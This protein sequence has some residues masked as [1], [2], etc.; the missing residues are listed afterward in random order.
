MKYILVFIFTILSFSVFPQKTIDTCFT[1][2]QIINIAHNIKQL[3]YSDSIKTNIIYHQDTII[4]EQ[5][6]IITNDSII[7]VNDSIVIAKFK[8]NEK[9]FNGIVDN[10]KKLGWMERILFF[11][12][13]VMP[14]IILGVLIVR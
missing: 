3:K 8:Q 4:S 12:Y 13:G 11:S 10:Y 5:K 9:M 1:K 7:I 14:G 6:K 2:S